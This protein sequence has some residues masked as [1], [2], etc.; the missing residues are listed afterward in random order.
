M[1]YM[2]IPNL[3]KDTTILEF[4][5]IYAMEKIHGTS[6]H[7]SYSKENG[8]TFF[9][10]G[11]KYDNFVQLF[12]KENL[13]IQFAALAQNKVIVYGEAYGG[14]QQGM[15]ATYGDQLKFVAFD[16]KMNG[17]W[18]DVNTAEILVFHYLRLDFVPYGR[19][20]AKLGY[21]DAER[22]R[23][24]EQ[25]KKNGMGE[26]HKREGVVL[27]P[28]KECVD[29]RGSRII[30]KHKRDEFKETRTPRPVDLEEMAIMAEATKIA[31]EWVMPMRLNHV[32]SQAQALLRAVK[33][34]EGDRK[35][36]ISDT[37]TIIQM[38][39]DDIKQEAKGEIVESKEADKAIGRSTA[40][41]YKKWLS[42]RL[43][44]GQ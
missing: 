12:D 34:L 28:I 40:L 5:E 15:K 19:I 39:I 31:K 8:L 7:I 25:A 37:G 13:L 3:Y 38:M 17:N 36:D 9:S 4:E 2:K 23:D 33:G 21:I 6:A 26:G 44:E 10:G 30:A 20:P 16:V 42:E 18:L 29:I 27:R 22:D 14:K 1:G 24:S 43:K 41:L 32:L 11:E 35:L